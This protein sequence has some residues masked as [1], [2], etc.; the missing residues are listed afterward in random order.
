MNGLIS[1]A[2]RLSWFYYNVLVLFVIY[3]S[4]CTVSSFLANELCM[5]IFH[6]FW[7]NSWNSSLKRTILQT[8]FKILFD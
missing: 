8:I 7:V 2:R 6:P 1:G 3:Y 4:E 5:P